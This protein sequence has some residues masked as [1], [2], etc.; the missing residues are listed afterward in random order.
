MKRLFLFMLLLVFPFNIYAAS[1]SIKASTSASNITL[2]NTFTVKVTVSSSGKLGS[3]Q[4]G[5]NYDKSKLSLVSGDQRVVA[6]GDGSVST[7]TYTYKF[8]AIAKGCAK[9][10]VED[11]RLIDWDTESSISVGN[12]SITINIKEPVV[13]N[14]SS[15]NNLKDLSVDGFSLSPSFDKNTLEY[16]V[17]VLN[18]TSEIK[19]GASLSDS[20]AKASGVGTFPVVEGTNEFS[21]V[22]TAENGSSKTYTLRVIVPEADPISYSFKSGVYT[23]LRKLPEGGPTGFV[24]S[25]IMFNGEEVLCLRSEQLG[26][27]LI[28]LRYNDKDSFYIYNER[29]NDVSLYNEVGNNDFRIYL[30]NRE[31]DLGLSKELIAINDE[32]VDGYRLTSNSSYYVISGINVSTGVEDFYLFESRNNTISFFSLDDYNELISNN[33]V[34]KIVSILLG[35]GSVLLTVVVIAL[36]SSKKKLE[37]V[38]KVS[39]DINKDNNDKE[40]KKDKDNVNDIENKDKKDDISLETK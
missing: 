39:R 17:T 14:Y 2:N 9:I 7:K 6:Y 24:S 36:N 22:V 31:L 4:F 30:T 38:L 10:S 32:M 25:S 16:T 21:V 20:K 15:D 27:T 19:I 40:K 11:T 28:Y 37:R 3:W 29:D 13:V 26:L 5:I 34:Y 12:S 18:S 8:K 33:D 23:I 1:G 35:V